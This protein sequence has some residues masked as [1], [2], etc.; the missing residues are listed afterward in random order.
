MENPNLRTIPACIADLPELMFLNV[1]DNPGLQIPEEILQKGEE[2][3]PGLIDF[4]GS[5]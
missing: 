1:R 2:M 3:N 5:N 4:S